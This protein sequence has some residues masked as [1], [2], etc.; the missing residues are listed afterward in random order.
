[1]PGDVVPLRQRSRAKQADIV[2]LRRSPVPLSVL[3]E[4]MWFW[5][6]RAKVFEKHMNEGHKNA[7]D[8]AMCARVA[9]HIAQ[10]CAEAAAPYLHAKPS[11]VAYEP[12]EIDEEAAEE[13]RH[14]RAFAASLKG[15]SNDNLQ[16]LYQ[17]LVRE[18][19][20]EANPDE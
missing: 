4:A 1:M 15:M 19:W 18:D 14:E 13:R 20:M 16:R 2:A 11:P 17:A 3:L 12:W 7:L 6:D 8:D 10:R 5:H 9:R